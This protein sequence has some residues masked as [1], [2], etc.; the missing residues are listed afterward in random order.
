MT[1]EELVDYVCTQSGLIENDDRE[2]CRKAISKRYELIFNSYLWKD[3]L[4]GV[5]VS[6]DPENDENHAEGIVLLPEDIDRVVAVRTNATSA[7]A[8]ATNGNSL[9]VQGLEYFY[10]IDYDRFS[11]TG[12]PV[13]FSIL[14][15]IWFVWRG[16]TG[17]QVEAA[18]PADYE[19]DI[20]IVWRDG[21]GRRYV[22]LLRHASLLNAAGTEQDT[23]VLAVTGAGTAAANGLY[24]SGEQQN[25]NPAYYRGTTQLD[26]YSIYY[27]PNTTPEYWVLRDSVGNRAYSTE[28]ASD[29][30]QLIGSDWSN[31]SGSGD[32]PAP[33]VAYGQSARIEI[34]SVFKPETEGDISFVPQFSN[35]AEG[36]SLADDL[37]R[38]PAYQ[39]LR[40]F[41]IPQSAL[42]LNVLGKR[43]FVPL[44]F[45]QQEPEIKN[46]DN[47][48]IAFGMAAMLKRGRQFGK[49]AAEMSEAVI[50]LQELAK[51]E[52]IQAAN[53]SRFIPES[54]FGDPYFSPGGYF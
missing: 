3:A 31:T 10:R 15:P 37:T 6:V 40:L 21:S 45:D 49:A 4:V 2:F 44:D 12:C 34:E 38:S 16:Y 47:C 28:F 51:L 43:K 14:Y 26:D 1:L 18:N 35:D 7:S 39:R 32:N 5:N 9:R 41:S 20:K 46:L 19:T 23:D 42:T 13:E 11:Q 36:E 33:T 30:E 8:I 25:D 48:L 24:T 53:N 17:L 50:L 54:G 52:T 22:Q 29:S 27:E